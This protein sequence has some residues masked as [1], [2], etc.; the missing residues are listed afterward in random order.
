[1]IDGHSI[2]GIIDVAAD[3]G[4]SP[5][6]VSHAL[7]GKRAVS[8]KTRLKI[9]ESVA[10]LNYQPNLVARGLR[11]QRT[12]TIALLVADISNPYYPE[13]AS[14]V[15]D[16]LTR[17]GYLPFVCNTN[18][19][20]EAERTFLAEFVARSVD[21]IIMH[22]MALAPAEIRFIVGR[23]VPVVIIG[24]DDGSHS[25]DFVRSDD[26]TGISAG[27]SYLHDQGH[28]SIG[29]ISGP[30]GIG[31][32]DAR[33]I[34]FRLAVAALG[35]RTDDEWIA[36]GPYTRDG[37]LDAGARILASSTPPTAIMCANDLIA[38]GAMDAARAAGLAI[39]SDIA[40]IGC[41]NIGIADLVSPRLTTIDNNARGVGIACAETLLLRIA[42]GPDAVARHT[43]LPTRLVIRQSA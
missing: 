13:V 43:A 42:D 9:Q 36:R 37:G 41:D 26:R 20:A 32:G 10:R 33:L 31:P 19:V 40:I 6:T 1:M 39:P 17:D 38:I 15:H 34:S 24:E 16:V 23:R 2:A 5:T 27:V 11:S 35:L 28:R 29:F 14:G 12:H 30:V 21:G 8:A 22:P 4:V 7:S 3:A 18:G 25:V